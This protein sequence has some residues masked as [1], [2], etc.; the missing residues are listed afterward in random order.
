LA[1]RVFIGVGGHEDHPGRQ[2][3]AE[4][5]PEAER[6][7]TGAWPIDMVEEATR[8]AERLRGRGYPSLALE[9]ELFPREFHITVPLLTMSRALR[10]LFDAPA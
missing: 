3:E 7:L 4:R 5:M 2:R 8:M 10:F 1:A 9:F 6:R